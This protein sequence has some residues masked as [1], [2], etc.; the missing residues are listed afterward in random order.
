MFLLNR[1]FRRMIREGDLRVIDHHGVEHRYGAPSDTIAPATM[2][3]TTAATA[4]AMAFSLPLGAA[5]GY[6]DGRLVMERGDVN[7]LVNLVTHNVRWSRDNPVRFALWRQA[8]FAG[9]LGQFNQAAR[10]KRNVAHHYDLSDRLYDLFL[11]KDR[12]YSCAYYTDPGNTLD[13]AELEDK[14]IR[15]ARYHDGATEAEM[16]RVIERVWALADAPSVPW[17]LA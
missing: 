4:R 6:M 13:R 15:L 8:A 14:A 12:Q 1:I 9:W 3:L 7:D 10:A 11:D 16:R 5:E 2:R 17:L